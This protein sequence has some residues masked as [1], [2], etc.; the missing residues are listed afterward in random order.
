MTTSRFAPARPTTGRIVVAS[1]NTTAGR[2]AL[3]W[4]ASE[5][6]AGPADRRMLLVRTYPGRP[7]NTFV[8]PAA[9]ISS[10]ELI[11]PEFARQVHQVRGQLGG[12]RVD[13]HIHFGNVADMLL[14]EAC[15]ADLLVTAASPLGATG[16][17]VT[18]GA[19]TGAT[20]VA[21]RSTPSRTT[22]AGPFAGHV[23]V[24]VDGGARDAG[25]IRFAFDYADRHGRPLLA[26]HAHEPGSGG[27]WTDDQFMEVHPLGHEFGLDL[28]DAA[29]AAARAVHPD[30]QVRRAVMRDRA[31]VSL[32]RA[33]AGAVLLVVGDRGRPA[34]ARHLLGSVSRHVL[35]HARCTVAVVHGDARATI[36]KE[37]KEQL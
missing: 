17:A 5:C 19:H 28:L 23:V 4:A 32:V 3:A 11:D 2:A 27:L 6:A 9:A 21:V 18:V 14:S 33:S 34:V 37:P 24:G 8:P 35:M 7:G 25:P 16:L 12:E 20:V 29:V 22:V 15:P 30:V 10:I 31:G 26:V 36:T 13:V 1:D